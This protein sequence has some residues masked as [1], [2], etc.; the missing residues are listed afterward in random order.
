MYELTI[1]QTQ[2]LHDNKG[3]A[4]KQRVANYA[5][6]IFT[7]YFPEGAEVHVA[8]KHPDTPTEDV[9]TKVSA[10]RPCDDN[11]MYNDLLFWFELWLECNSGPDTPE[12]ADVNVLLTN[13]GNGGGRAGPKICGVHDGPDIADAPPVGKFDRYRTSDAHDALQTALHEIGHCIIYDA[14]SIAEHETGAVTRTDTGWFTNNKHF[15]TPMGLGGDDHAD[16]CGNTYDR[17]GDA[18]WDLVW[19]ECMEAHRKPSSN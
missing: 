9:K 2:S 3:N 15:R 8:E 14:Y 7:N 10:Q 5:E 1:F 12:A 13:K 19:S 6:H 4:P 11:Y 17:P 18:H 16:V